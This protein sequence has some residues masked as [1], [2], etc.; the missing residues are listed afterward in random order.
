[1][2]VPRDEHRSFV[3]GGGLAK[4]PVLVVGE[5]EELLA[6]GGMIQLFVEDQKVRFSINHAN[7]AAAGLQ[8]SSRLL[9]LA[10]TV[11]GAPGGA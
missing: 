4:R 8:V 1:L 9:R 10:R 3:T 7:A 5:H 6:D 11:I 2:Y